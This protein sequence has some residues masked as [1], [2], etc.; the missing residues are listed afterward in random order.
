MA[1]EPR[2]ANHG[3]KNRSFMTK[4]LLH[5]AGL[6]LTPTNHTDKLISGV[7]G[8]VA[9]AFMTW[10]THWLCGPEAL[11]PVVASMG[12][13]AVLLFAA[14][15][16]Q[17]SQPWPLA[18]GHILS[19]TSGVICARFIPN[20]LLAG[21]A[22][23]GLAITA[24][25]YG[26]CIHPP[27]GATAL[28]AVLRA[29]VVGKLGFSYILMPVSLN[30]LVILSVAVAFNFAFKWRRYPAGLLKPR[31]SGHRIT[32]EDWSHALREIGTMADITEDELIELYERALRHGRAHRPTPAA[33]EAHAA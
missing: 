23:V 20:P 18:M 15:H 29:S 28:T 32:R 27:G 10:L 9:I 2:A 24:M 11:M 14:P 4:N 33:R 8:F 7:G 13:S 6:E 12:A 1:D 25:Y 31:P 17:L 30:V 21:S 19:A 22:A 5:L 16:G 3:L 26:R